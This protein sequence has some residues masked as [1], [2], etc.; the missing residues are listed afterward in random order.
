V[1]VRE[2]IS[3]SALLAQLVANKAV[4]FEQ[5]P[6][7]W[8]QEYSKVLQ[9]VGWVVQDLAWN[10]YAAEGLEVDVH[11]KIVD[12]MAAV[13]GPSAAAL[14]IITA[15]I[16]ALKAMNSSS[17]WITLFKRESQ[18]ARIARFQIGLVDKDADGGVFVVL[19]GCVI[20]A[21]EDITQVLFFKVK[22]E[23]ASFEGSSAKV[24]INQ[25]ALARLDTKIREKI[26]DYQDD[27]LSTI[28]NV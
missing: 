17:P 12:V 15:T 7:R 8:F 1:E 27:Y 11:E 25:P 23:K 4:K 28:L 20:K 6:K 3:D 13:L 21:Q 2:A 10:N 24:S 16:G 9:N 5:D 22:K 19:I 26:V 18:K 14:A